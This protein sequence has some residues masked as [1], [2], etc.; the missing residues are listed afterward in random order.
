MDNQSKAAGISSYIGL[1]AA[2]L[3]LLGPGLIHLGVLS[4]LAG[5]RR[6]CN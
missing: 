6:F 4:P 3:A 2:T 5:I 1:G